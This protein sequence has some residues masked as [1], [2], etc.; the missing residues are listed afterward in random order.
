MRYGRR[1][2]RNGWK[3]RRERGEVRKKGKNLNERNI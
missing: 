1:E 2:K 3:R